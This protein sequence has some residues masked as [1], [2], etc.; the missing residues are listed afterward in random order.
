MTPE[1]TRSHALAALLFALAVSGCHGEPRAETLSATAERFV[2]ALGSAEA[3]AL[4]PWLREGAKLLRRC[5]ACPRARRVVESTL[6]FA[7]GGRDLAA[8]LNAAPGAEASADTAPLRTGSRRCEGACCTWSVG[9]LDHGAVHL[10]RA[11][12]GHHP[13]GPHLTSLALVDG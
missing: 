12:F 6:T 3:E 4:A 9:L 8:A 2:D 5:P 7:R 1:V 10:E 11:C 13:D